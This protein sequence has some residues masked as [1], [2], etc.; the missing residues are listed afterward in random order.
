MLKII[1]FNF[2]EIIQKTNLRQ[3]CKKY[4]NNKMFVQTTYYKDNMWY[5]LCTETHGLQKLQK[6][7]IIIVSWSQPNELNYYRVEDPK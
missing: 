6:N 5:M 3:S 7:I 1:L 4:M 2:F